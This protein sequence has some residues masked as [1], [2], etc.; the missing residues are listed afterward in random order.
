MQSL[1]NFRFK[2]NQQVGNLIQKPP[3]NVEKFA[4]N[5]PFTNVFL[6]I[7]HKK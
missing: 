4:E 1:E 6:P 5:Q 3:L 2:K 7:Y